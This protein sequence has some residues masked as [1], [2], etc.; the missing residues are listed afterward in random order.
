MLAITAAFLIAGVV[1]TYLARLLGMDFMTVRTTY[2]AFWLFWV[3]AAWPVLFLPGVLA[4]VWDSFA[5]KA[6]R[7]IALRDSSGTWARR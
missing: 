3:S 1:Q 7:P 2:V 4:F 6:A 5:G